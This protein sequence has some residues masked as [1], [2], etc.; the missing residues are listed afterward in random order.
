[1]QTFAF[2]RVRLFGQEQETGGKCAP[3]QRVT[4]GSPFP[5]GIACCVI[6]DKSLNLSEGHVRYFQSTW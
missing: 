5:D 1:M 6:L 4:G 2:L 3:T